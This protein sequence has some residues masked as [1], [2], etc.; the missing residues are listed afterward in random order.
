MHAPRPLLAVIVSTLLLL[1]LIGLSLFPYGSEP[2]DG[3][4][5]LSWRAR[6]ERVEECRKLTPEELAAL[7]GHMR[8]EEICEGRLAPYRLS[9]RIDDRQ[10]YDNTVRPAGARADRPIYVHREYRLSPGEHRLEVEFRLEDEG[11]GIASAEPLVYTGVIQVN[12]GDVALLTVDPASRELV[13]RGVAE[14]LDE[15]RDEPP[16]PAD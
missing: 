8:R 9:I 13:V 14:R 11:V 3:L 12:A 5:R 2:E 16:E 10:V 15:A 6:G 7:P 1:A 4:L